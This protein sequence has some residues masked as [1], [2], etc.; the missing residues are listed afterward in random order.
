MVLDFLR[1]SKACRP[2]K[3]LDMGKAEDRQYYIDFSSVRGG[4]II[5]EI[6]RTITLSPDEQTCQLLTGHIGCGKSTELL[7]LKS[8]LEKQKIHVVYF[9]SSQDLDLVDVG[10]SDILLAIAGRISENLESIGIKLRPRFFTNLLADI[11]KLLNTPIE[12]GTEL[13]VGIA[14]ITAKTKQNPQERSQLREYL[15]SK[16]SNL[17]TSINEEILAK[18][19]Q[20]LK[21]RGKKGLVVIVD[22]LDRV[23][24]RIMASGR[25]LPEYLFIDQGSQ[26]GGL[27][28]HVVYTIPLSLK[29]S[30]DIE[31]LTQ[32]LGGG[33][34][35]RILPMV[36]VQMK[37]GRV[38]EAGMEQL[39]QMVLIRAFPNLSE[40]ER[41][42]Q[43]SEVFDSSDT[44]E[45]LCRV[46]GGH[47]R[48][49][50]ALLSSCCI[51]IDDPPIPYHY[52]ERVIR[53]ER[54]KLA[55]AIREHQWELLR[56]VKQNK[57]IVG[58]DPEYQKLLRSMFVYEYRD[59]YAGSWF[60]I[61]PLLAEAEELR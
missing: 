48:K 24:N 41:L 56:Q 39:R 31:T 19:N 29:F 46:S 7:R 58:S 13:S 50:V 16:T 27:N 30:S 49:V 33:R 32:R 40:Q 44:L 25:T 22:N 36:P 11:V 12:I 38:C 15:E 17:L 45:R 37:D 55:V 34:S 59:E 54:N 35:P 51:Q 4:E 14:K 47:V 61:N 42:Q 2:D 5:K 52:L 57:K 9:E 26:L 8:E 43:I 3:A 6:A 21:E 10:I 53:E 1:F 23:N 28:C 20:E 60:D 18:A